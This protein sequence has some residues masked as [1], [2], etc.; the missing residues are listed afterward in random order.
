MKKFFIVLAAVLSVASCKEKGNG[1][2]TVD[3][4]AKVPD[5]G[6][7][8]VLA[9]H[10]IPGEYTSEDMYKEMRNAGF[11]LTYTNFRSNNSHLK[12]ALDAAEK[13]GIKIYLRCYDLEGPSKE[14]RQAIVDT[15]KDHPAL[16]GWFLWDEPT[17]TA[18][19]DNMGTWRNEI[20][21]ADDSHICYANLLPDLG[22]NVFQDMGLTDYEGYMDY[23]LDKLDPTFLSCAYYPIVKDLDGKV[24]L[25]QDL[26]FPSLEKVSTKAKRERIPFWA[27]ALSTAHTPLHDPNRPNVD[28]YDEHFPIPT[29]EHLRIQMWNNLAY[30]SQVLQY[31]TY[32]TPLRTE[33]SQFWYGGGPKESDGKTGPAYE[34]VKAMN[35]EIQKL[36]GVFNGCTMKW[37]RHTGEKIPAKTRRL[38][39]MPAGVSAL[40]TSEP[41]AT[42]SL[43]ENQGFTFLVLVSRTLDDDITVSMTP[44]SQKVKRVDKD[45]SIVD[46]APDG[47]YTVTPGDILIFVLD[48]PGK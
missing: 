43:I 22:D 6:E 45:A 14:K 3:Y 34:V 10:S 13:A 19:I 33:D 47:K 29:I 21:E 38:T 42:V 24:H 8:P 17:G 9:W 39:E 15:Y 1:G 41:G 44:S 7:I 27:F 12:P 23:Y 16:A 18:I 20:M 5:V 46:L 32:W 4:P 2:A 36:N 28:N 30:G 26:W 31:F 40:E 35:K 37:V 25:Y 48:G 11:T